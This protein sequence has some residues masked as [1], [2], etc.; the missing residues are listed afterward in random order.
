LGLSIYVSRGEPGQLEA[1]LKDMRPVPPVMARVIS[2]R[3]VNNADQWDGWNDDERRANAQATADMEHAAALNEYAA[4]LSL[5][6][7]L[8]HD[9]RIIESGM[10]D[11]SAHI[12]KLLSFVNQE[13]K[14]ED[15][16]NGRTSVS[17][18]GPVGLAH[19]I[20]QSAAAIGSDFEFFSDHQ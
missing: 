4:R 9:R 20:S 13:T 14:Q 10:D 2:R 17:Y 8:S 1:F 12:S 15:G 16:H 5:F 19:V 18:C 3:T 7:W 11:R 6:E